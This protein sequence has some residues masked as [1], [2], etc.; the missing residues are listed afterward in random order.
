MGFLSRKKQIHFDI[1]T[2]KKNDITIL[3]LD[4]RWNRLFRI[5]PINAAVKK[6]QDFLNKLLAQEA[7]LYQ[8]KNNI[9]PEKKKLINT[10]ISLTPEAFDKNDENAKLTLQKSKQRIEALNKR[11]EELEE[12]LYEKREEIRR[13]NFKLLE[14]TV[15]LVYSV[16]RKSRKREQRI[17]KEINSLKKRLKELQTLKQSITTDWTDVY[18]FFHTLLGAEELTKLDKLFLKPEVEN[19]EDGESGSNEKD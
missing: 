8:E 7:G 10:I 2:L 16:M 4:E 11:A 12:E 15:R 6:R 14:E 1:A 19:H 3:T 17:E 9:D 5:I 13:A 18:A